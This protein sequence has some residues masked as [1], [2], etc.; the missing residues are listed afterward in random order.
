[1]ASW[2]ERRLWALFANTAYALSSFVLGYLLLLQGNNQLYGA[3]AF[4]LLIQAFA[5]SLINALFGAPLLIAYRDEKVDPTGLNPMLRLVMLLAVLCALLQA[6]LLKQQGI[7]ID[8][9]SLLAVSSVLLQLRWF[10]RCVQQ[11]GDPE[12][13]MLADGWF[14]LVALFGAASLSLQGMVSLWSLSLLL[15]FATVVSLLPSGR[16]LWTI[17][18]ASP[19]WRLWS[20]GFTQQGKPALT[21]VV[22]VEATTNIHQYLIVLIQ[23]SAALAPVAA[24][25]LFLRPMTLVQSSL[26]QIDRPRL[27][28]AAVAADWFQLLHIWRLFLRLSLLAFVVNLVVLVF[29][30][31][32]DPAT[33]WPDLATLA[34]FIL[35]GSFV[36]AA[37]LL[38]SLRGPASTLLQAFD[39]FQF[40]A[41]VTVRASLV[42]VPLVLLGILV[43]GIFGALAAM[44]L[45]ECL[46]AIPI[47]RRCRRMLKTE[48]SP[49]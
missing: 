18:C 11:N 22:T 3:F 40:L 48:T 2:R 21:G 30:L 47:L 43:G 42:T 7:S 1:M 29:L 34:H 35:C 8:E 14:S 27:A 4:Y 31:W 6:L 36:A 17:L 45:G 19:D 10:F 20:R 41:D 39:Q 24:A 16:L 13:V 5:Y 32:I 25:G 33:L 26:A 9:M 23:G 12:Q 28:R 44:V 38:R 46:V 49:C 15:L 37:A